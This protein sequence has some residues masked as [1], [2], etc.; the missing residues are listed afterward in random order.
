MN[1][2]IAL[3]YWAH[4]MATASIL[5]VGA[6]FNITA[7]FFGMN[8]VA[9]TFFTTTGEIVLTAWFFTAFLTGVAAEFVV[10]LEHRVLRIVRRVVTVYMF[11]LTMAHGVNNLLLGNVEGYTRIFSGPVYTY[12]ALVVLSTLTIVIASLPLASSRITGT[13][14]TANRPA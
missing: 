10:P 5:A 3:V 14:G 6:Y 12:T 8:L 1:S 9:T 7:L 11:M 2:R 4:K 13:H